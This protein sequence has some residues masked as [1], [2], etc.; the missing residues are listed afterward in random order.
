MRV[1]FALPGLHRYDRGAEIA[2]IS[3]AKELAILGHKI[4][5]IGSGRDRENTPYRFLRAGSVPREVFEK[6]P[7]IPILRNEYAYEELTFVPSLARAYRPAEYDVTVT[8][9]Y[10]FT[11]WLLRRPMAN[12][13][14]PPHVYVTENGDW[15]AFSDQSE[16]RWFGCEGLICT[17]P[18]FYERNKAKWNSVLIPNGVDCERFRPGADQRHK[19][20]LPAGRPIILMAS[21]LIP[22][23]R[24][25]LAI[26]AV[27]QIQ[28]AHLVIAGDGPLR[29]H[30]ETAAKKLLFDRFTLLSVPAVQMP[31]L[32][33]SATVF[34]HLSKE[35]AFGN[36]FLEAMAS[37]LPIVAHGSARTAWLVGDHQFLINTENLVDIVCAISDAIQLQATYR[38]ESLARAKSFSWCRIGKMYDD[39]LQTVVRASDSSFRNQAPF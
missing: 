36:V 2:F 22:T 27:A 33:Q 26:E 23:K 35:E 1:L 29:R 25:E 6:F 28:N 7:S 13:R 4:S 16:Y 31:S 19:F 10:P 14:R 39:F 24:V 32:Y 3:V 18:E 37:G 15:P 21:A 9:N 12:G 17:N 34:L 8:C 38:E 11:N 20:G 5:L 30:I